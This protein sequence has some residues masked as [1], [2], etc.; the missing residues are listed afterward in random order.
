MRG[1]FLR[2]ATI[3]NIKFLQKEKEDDNG[4]ARA[5]CNPEVYRVSRGGEVTWH[6]P[7]QLVAYPL[8]NLANPWHKK[9]LRWYVY[10]LEETIIQTLDKI[11]MKGE[12][13]PINPG[14]WVGQEKVAAVGIGASR[15]ITMHGVS[16]NIS[17]DLSMYKNIIPCG[18]MPEVGGVSSIN[19]LLGSVGNNEHNVENIKNHFLDSFSVVFGIELSY[20]GFND[21]KYNLENIVNKHQTGFENDLYDP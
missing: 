16:L 9:D 14:V 12:R 18:I 7:G 4:E 3:D 8:I 19:K 5:A 2:G 17:C 6:G 15:W 20:V 1:V 21:K 13:S 10:Q 11:G